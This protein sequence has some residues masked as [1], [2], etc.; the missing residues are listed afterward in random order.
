MRIP[1]LGTLNRI[2]KSLINGFYKRALILLYHR[3]NERT[4]DP[5]LLNVTPKHFNEHLEILS[6]K[7]N[8]ISLSEMVQSIEK[9]N[10][11]HKTI[12]ITFDDGYADNLFF[13]KPYLV[14]HNI[15]A[16]VYISCDHVENNK[17]FWWDSLE[18]IFLMTGN[19][20]KVL[21]INIDSKN[22]N[23]IFENFDPYMKQS[24]NQYRNW[25]IAYEVDPTARH[26]AYRLFCQL[27][28][29]LSAT[30][31]QNALNEL[32]K[33][34]NINN[35]TAAYNY[36][37]LTAAEVYELV[38][39]DLIEVG[40]HTM[41]H[42]VLSELTEEE[43]RFEI[44]K[45]KSYLETIIKQPVISFSYP[46]GTRNDY[47]KETVDIVRQLNFTNACSNFPEMV[48]KSTDLFQLPRFV[49]RNWN[50]KEFDLQL[51]NWFK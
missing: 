50:G 13:A 41:T 16:L 21:N 32:F 18:R 8:V 9:G 23:L 2:S 35:I 29:P 34:A 17:E 19:L 22:Y 44:Q 25:N 28:R 7:W 43:Q 37:A 40:A 12:A 10:V 24:F 45:S 30:S 4:N 11:P 31:R 20:P 42:S 33:W 36:R 39:G 1:G 49:I 6:K 46:F 14:Q 48:V 5:Q 47:T 15:P 27:L 26:A 38:N 51:Q 3:I